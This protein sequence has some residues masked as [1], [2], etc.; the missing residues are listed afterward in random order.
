MYIIGRHSIGRLPQVGILAEHAR[1]STIESTPIETFTQSATGI[2][3]RSPES[4]LDS[5]SS[6]FAADRQVAMNEGFSRGFGIASKLLVKGYFPGTSL[7]WASGMEQAIAKEI[8]E[9]KDPPVQ[10]LMAEC[11]MTTCRI[12]NYWPPHPTQLQLGKQVN[13][14]YGLELDHLGEAYG[15]EEGNGHLRVE[16]VRRR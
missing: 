2:A 7:Q 4:L 16:I 10:L 8:A 12:S 14:L 5:E 1:S 6:S 13:N 11:R 3:D 15:I 9:W